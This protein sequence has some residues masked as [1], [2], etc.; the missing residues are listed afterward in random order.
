MCGAKR[1]W[2]AKR[3]HPM[4][5]A[6]PR[7]RS[8]PGPA[9]SAGF[10][11]QPSLLAGLL[12][13]GRPRLRR[14]TA[15][16]I[17]RPVRFPGHHIAAQLPPAAQARLL[18]LRR[19]YSLLIATGC[20]VRANRRSKGTSPPLPPQSRYENSTDP[21]HRP[22]WKHLQHRR[23]ERGARRHRQRA[24]GGFRSVPCGSAGDLPTQKRVTCQG[25]ASASL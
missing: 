10:A 3:R 7:R 22:V 9:A 13:L 12:A 18:D 1:T 16:R 19:D 5:P 21:R 4:P 23:V 25:L 14:P 17:G 15:W 6:P 8:G 20:Q 11:H 2:T 24:D